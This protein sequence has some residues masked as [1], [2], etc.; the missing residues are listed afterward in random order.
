MGWE[1]QEGARVQSVC[2]KTAGAP[3][4]QSAAGG[5]REAQVR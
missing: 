4:K 5:P 2:Q 3:H 1:L